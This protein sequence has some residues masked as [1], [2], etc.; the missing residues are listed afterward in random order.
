MRISRRVEGARD[1]AERSGA[2]HILIAVMLFSFLVTAAMTIDFAYMQLI[3][4]ELRT[5]TDAAARA[6]AE[7]LNRTQDPAA[8]IQ[9]A[10]DYAA[11]NNVAGRPFRIAATDVELGRVARQ[12]NGR[13]SF[14][15]GESPFNSVRINANINDA[16]TTKSI[17][18][19]FGPAFGHAG[20]STHTQ[21]V[22]GQQEVEVMLCL[23]RSGSMLFDMS[24]IDYSY[25]TGNGLLSNF[26]AWGTIWQYHLSPP[27]PVFSRWAVLRRAVDV[28]FDEASDQST[29][30]R[31]G[32]VTWGS[33]YQ[34]P[35]SP[36]TWYYASE[37]DYPLPAKAGFDW[38]DSVRDMKQDLK[39]RQLL[40]MMGGTNMEAGIRAATSSLT[41]GNSRPLSNKV[42]ILLTDGQ[43][44]AGNDPIFAAQAAA[45]QNITI[46]TVSMLTTDQ[47]ILRDI[48]NATGGKYYV[49]QNEA[50]LSAAFRELARTLPVVMTE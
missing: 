21:A 14:E 25:P 5:A 34:M 4:T 13:W 32:L 30:P 40:P 45:S 23:D 42:I 48:A 31:T 10:V 49:T 18:T 27:H 26:T 15:A 36:Y 29:P 1:T 37:T 6:G 28:F 50:E 16:A 44:N 35:I 19:F 2:A 9:A 39:H 24:G 47:P 46:H 38:K 43:W 11:L 41:G 7:A 17:P 12:P 33:D 22:A 3:R 8:A 20:F